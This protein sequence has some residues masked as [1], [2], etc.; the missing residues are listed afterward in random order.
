[1]EQSGEKNTP[2]DFLK[3]VKGDLMGIVRE[4]LVYDVARHVD[5]SVELFE[6]W[7]CPL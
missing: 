6:E 1:M 4:D 5:S 3:Y 2:E 7:G